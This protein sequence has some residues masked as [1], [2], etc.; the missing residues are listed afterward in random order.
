MG[1]DRVV[2]ILGLSPVHYDGRQIAYMAM[3][4]KLHTCGHVWFSK[5]SD[6]ATIAFLFVCN[7]Y[8]LIID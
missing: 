5:F 4:D 1:H 8:C 7:N 6:I 2:G 3:E